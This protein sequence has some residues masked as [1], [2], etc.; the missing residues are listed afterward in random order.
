MAGS[1]PICE[2]V[3]ALKTPSLSEF[4]APKAR[5]SFDGVGRYA[6]EPDG[7]RDTPDN[8]AWPARRFRR[9]Q[10]TNQ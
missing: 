7:G 9:G 5:L 2:L 6:C 4:Q 1:F 8:A 10:E 3:A